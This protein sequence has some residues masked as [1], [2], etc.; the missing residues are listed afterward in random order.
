ME[1]LLQFKQTT[2]DLQ[3]NHTLVSPLDLLKRASCDQNVQ[4]IFP[5]EMPKF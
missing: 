4:P 3:Y 1:A 2:I 5:L